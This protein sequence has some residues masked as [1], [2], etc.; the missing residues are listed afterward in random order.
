MR[1]WHKFLIPSLPKQ[2]LVVQWREC[3]A[4]AGML[5]TG[6]LKPYLVSKVQ[7]YPIQ[8]FV[9]YCYIVLDEMQNRG[10][11]VSKGVVDKIESLLDDYPYISDVRDYPISKIF[12]NWHNDRYL[13]QCFYNLE[14]KYDCGLI[15]EEEFKPILYAF[16]EKSLVFR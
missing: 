15:T 4:V 8:Q 6:T 11:R 14:E 10:Y 9:R 3:A 12:E 2:Q 5:K 1:L 16:R 7:D 13:R